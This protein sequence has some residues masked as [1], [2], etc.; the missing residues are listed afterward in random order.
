MSET[1]PEKIREPLDLQIGDDDS[2]QP[3]VRGYLLRLLAQVW[4][5][6]ED[7]D[8]KRP[9]GNS[10][11]RRELY[12]PMEGAGL[13]DGGP[14]ERVN[15][16]HQQADALILAAIAAL[17]VSRE[18]ESKPARVIVVT[19]RGGT[20]RYAADDMDVDD[21]ALVLT[22]GDRCDVVALRAPHDWARAHQDGVLLPDTAAEVLSERDELRELLAEVLYDA[23]PSPALTGWIERAQ[24]LGVKGWDGDPI[25]A[26][27]SDAIEER[28]L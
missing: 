13:I 6:E 16:A 15:I 19:S 22:R 21:G 7:F 14:D 1:A 5:E 20:L 26:A 8:G 3:T 24:S 2:G 9:F 25:G 10:N 12:A 18:P 28:D 17:D 23:T 4:T 11:W 27:E